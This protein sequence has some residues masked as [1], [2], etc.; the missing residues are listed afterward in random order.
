[1]TEKA[2]TSKKLAYLYT[3]SRE[4]N[5]L[6]ITIFHRFERNMNEL[7]CTS[8]FIILFVVHGSSP[9]FKSYLYGEGKKS[10]EIKKTGRK[11]I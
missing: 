9:F 5:T 2:E 11:S 7:L 1:M 4:I 3:T 10:T 8:D 6:V